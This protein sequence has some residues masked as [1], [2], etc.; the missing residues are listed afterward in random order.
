MLGSRPGGGRFPHEGPDHAERFGQRSRRETDGVAE[1][2]VVR[3]IQALGV[4]D[5]GEPARDA[6]L[7]HPGQR[8]EPVGLPGLDLA[9]ERGEE[10][11]REQHNRH[12]GKS[13]ERHG[14]RVCGHTDQ[15]RLDRRDQLLDRVGEG[16]GL[17]GV[18]GDGHVP[19]RAADESGRRSVDRG[20]GD[21]DVGGER[22]GHQ[23]R[24]P[25]VAERRAHDE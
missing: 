2:Y 14:E 8:T 21:V 3:E 25:D 17:S 7:V 18:V 23:R 9:S 12:R 13:D 20:E 15:V 22:V 24:S 5:R 1:Q 19:P 4:A 11:V 16:F 10:P 6:P